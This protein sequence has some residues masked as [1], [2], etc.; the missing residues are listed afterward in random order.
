MRRAEGEE[1]RGAEEVLTLP[2]FLGHGIGLR[3]EHYADV[4]AGAAAC[5]WLEAISENYM[6][7]GGRARKVL[8]A[9]RERYPIALHGVSLGVGNSGPLD[10]GY[11]AELKSLAAEVEPAWVSDH[12]CWTGSRGRTTHDLL[13]LPYTREALENVVARVQRVQERL[14]RPIVLE[15]VS[16]YVAWRGSTLSEEEFLA[17]VA[18]RSGCGLLL[19]VNNVWV[20]ATNH[21]RDPRAFLEAIPRGSVWQIHLAGPSQAGPLLVDSHDHPVRPEVWELYREAVRRFGEVS[22]LVEWDDRIPELSV[23]LAERDRAA[24]IA[25]E[26]RREGEPAPRAGVPDTG[27][28]PDPAAPTSGSGRPAAAGLEEAQRLFFDL[29]T[30]PESV[31]KTLEARGAGARRRVEELLAGDDRLDAVGRLEVYAQAYFLRVRDALLEDFPRTAAALGEDRWHNLVTDFLV[32]RPPTRWSLRWA[33]E[34]LPALLQTN[35]LGAE[36]PWLADAAELEQARNEAFQALD[37]E[38][39]IARLADVPAAAW[40]ELRFGA[41]PGTALVETDWDLASWW[42]TGEAPD[43]VPGGQVL[44]VTRDAEDDVR[45]EILP[46]G[47]VPGVRLLLAGAPFSRVCEAWADRGSPEDAGRAAIAVLAGTGLRDALHPLRAPAAR[48]G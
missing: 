6:A 9:V 13:P 14:G 27:A 43:R 10:D 26:V 30:A 7:V 19:D 15:N 3:R 22:T 44:L 40:P 18:R 28:R 23:V 36:R 4:L 11:L 21:G 1:R 34:A 31:A 39:G 25:A 5:D 8:L 16:T 24:A 41:V 45:H 47:D 32:A 38:G 29:V 12:L 2:P 20:S 17:E 48:A 46:D 42:E 33:G 37:G 35:P